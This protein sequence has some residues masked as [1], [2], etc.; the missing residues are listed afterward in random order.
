MFMCVRQ[1]WPYIPTYS[2]SLSYT[3]PRMCIL[4][5][6]RI[7]IGGCPSMYVYVY[8]CGFYGY[9]GGGVDK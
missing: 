9:S 1:Y 4:D 3:I 5:I 2:P 6:F 7:Y 8:V